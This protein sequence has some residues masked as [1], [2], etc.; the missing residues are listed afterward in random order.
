M[1]G[2][3]LI[4]GRPNVG[5]STLFNRLAG[6]K[7]AIVGN[8]VGVTRD[9]REQDTKIAS[10]IF[11]IFDTAGID[12]LT[13]NEL[14]RNMS[15]NSISL[16]NSRDTVIFLID[17]KAGIL[18]DDFEVAKKLRK[19]NCDVIL[20]VNKCEGS[21]ERDIF[22][23]GFS[24]GFGTPVLI[25]A[26]HGLGLN[27][28][29]DRVLERVDYRIGE[30]FKLEPTDSIDSE[31]GTKP[32]Q[33]SIVGRPNSGKSTFFNLLL[34]EQRSLTGPE[35]GLTRDA[36]GV[37]T[38]WNGLNIKLF[39]T[40]GMR[41]KNKVNSRL[42]KLSVQ[43]SVKAIN[44]SEIV[45]ILLDEANAFDTQD[46]KISEVVGREGRV[47][48]FAVNKWDLEKEKSSR[49]NS[50]QKKL[51]ELLPQFSGAEI[52]PVS[53]KTGYGLDKLNTVIKK[54][55]N[56]WNKRIPTAELNTWLSGQISH[57]PPPM[58]RRKRLKIRYVTQAKSRPPTFIFFG[59]RAEEVPKSYERY[60][61]NSLRSTFSIK[62]V[63]IRLLFRS[64]NNPYSS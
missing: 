42:E 24:L 5:K 32:I 11:R 55:H 15:S 31:P 30:I 40:A 28:L 49:I 39:D 56:I 17:G 20:V 46:L 23:E 3:I 6:K 14:K 41:R 34:N 54:Y 16:L 62:G 8:E 18:S 38:H 2:N 21:H 9:I 63:P 7:L 1:A 29:K 43:D 51:N 4:I 44:F 57:H 64:S 33:M 12:T 35:S 58:I 53:A 45:I 10:E 61:I 27:D 25:S 26:E 13:K 50:L 60:L 22:S 19:K 36:I 59:S 48:I 47:P 37:V 52:V